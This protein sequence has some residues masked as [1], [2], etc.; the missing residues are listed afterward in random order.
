MSLETAV[1]TMFNLGDTLFTDRAHHGEPQFRA[2]MVRS[3]YDARELGLKEA[4]EKGMQWAGL[5]R[6]PT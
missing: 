3:G 1:S 6:K 5:K 4:F 2:A